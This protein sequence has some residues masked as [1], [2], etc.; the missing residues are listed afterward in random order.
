MFGQPDVPLFVSA[1]PVLFQHWLMGIFSYTACFFTC[2]ISSSRAFR[3]KTGSNHLPFGIVPVLSLSGTNSAPAQSVHIHSSD[4][5]SSIYGRVKSKGLTCVPL[6]MCIV[7]DVWP[8]SPTEDLRKNLGIQVL[9]T[10]GS[11]HPSGNMWAVREE[12]HSFS[13][14]PVSCV[15]KRLEDVMP[16]LQAYHARERELRCPRH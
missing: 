14:T 15:T 16:A 12:A 8:A 5:A 1:K 13:I 2:C 3:T 7:A 6:T 4:C 9:S 11:F 10:F